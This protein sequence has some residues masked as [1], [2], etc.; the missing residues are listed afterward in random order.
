MP[1][2]N[3]VSEVVQAMKILAE[4]VKRGESVEQCRYCV[5]QSLRLHVATPM[6]LDGR[7]GEDF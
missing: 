3:E 5:Y 7:E 2:N 1:L 4:I 6:V